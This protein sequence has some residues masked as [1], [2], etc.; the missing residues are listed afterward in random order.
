[1]ATFIIDGQAHKLEM[2][3]GNGIDWSMDF[4]GS[5]DH[6]MQTDEDG[7][8]V[9]TQ[10]EYDWW[11]QAIADQETIQALIAE[12]KERHGDEEVD[13][14]LSDAGALETDLD[15]MLDQVKV[16]LSELDA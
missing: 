16:A 4:I 8:F 11:K 1:M 14:W 13:R 10:A 5:Y 12:C 3:D 2:R 7:N 15:M 6:E 9:T